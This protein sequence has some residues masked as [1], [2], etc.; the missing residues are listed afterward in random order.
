MDDKQFALLKYLSN[1]EKTDVGR[2]MVSIMNH[3]IDVIKALEIERYIRTN[4]K[5]TEGLITGKGMIACVTESKKRAREEESLPPPLA[6]WNKNE[7][8]RD[9]SDHEKRAAE[10]LNDTQL[11][12]LLAVYKA[13]GDA[14]WVEVDINA[15]TR[16]SLVKY[17]Y[18]EW[19]TKRGYLI[20]GPGVAQMEKELIRRGQSMVEEESSVRVGDSKDDNGSTSKVKPFHPHPKSLPAEQGG[21]SIDRDNGDSADV[22]DYVTA[23]EMNSTILDMADAHCAGDCD[24]C[25][26]RDVLEMIAAKY[27]KVAELRDA[28]LAQKRLVDELGLD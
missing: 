7:L 21:T 11:D 22:P 2:A 17:G 12:A 18:L 9:L 10:N 23:E 4:P 6:T 14:D 27:P 3:E 20:N 24:D 13:G 16:K 1:I 25:V 8:H 28:I 26:H 19:S 15:N 5:R